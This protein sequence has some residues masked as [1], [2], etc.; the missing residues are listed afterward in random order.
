MLNHGDGVVQP[1][2]PAALRREEPEEDPQRR[3]RTLDRSRRA[4]PSNPFDEAGH[5][6]VCP[7]VRTVALN[8]TFGSREVGHC[9]EVS[10]VH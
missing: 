4:P 3:R 1:I 9:G 2:L 7:S 5:V 10:E 8:G 6:E